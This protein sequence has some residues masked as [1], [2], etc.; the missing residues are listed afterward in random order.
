[1][2]ASTLPWRHRP[3]TRLLPHRKPA[4]PFFQYRYDRSGVQLRREHPFWAIT[5]PR[6]ASTPPFR[7]PSAPLLARQ[8]I[9]LTLSK[10][11]FTVSEAF[12]S[13]RPHT[14]HEPVGRRVATIDLRIARVR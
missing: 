10:P 8:C 2:Q 5:K 7:T 9:L 3:V 11:S 6:S 4:G 12:F 14:Y 1:M 13:F